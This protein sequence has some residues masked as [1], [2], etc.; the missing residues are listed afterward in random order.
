VV[1]GLLAIIAVPARATAC[2]CGCGVF[3]VGSGLMYP[4]KLGGFAAFEYDYM[5]QN[6]NWSGTSKAPAA[7]N[8][9]KQIKTNFY[10]FN[11]Q[12]MFN[13]DWGLAVNVPYWNRYFLTTDD[14]GNLWCEGSWGATEC[15]GSN[16]CSA[17]FVVSNGFLR[18]RFV[19]PVGTAALPSTSTGTSTSGLTNRAASTAASSTLIK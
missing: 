2:A 1:L 14:E 9:D 18:N 7:D 17:A 6:Q 11:F 8:D 12:Y 19:S 13:Q 4:T 15:T 5:N 3:E 16:K 10:N